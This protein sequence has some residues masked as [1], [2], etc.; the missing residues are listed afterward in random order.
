M[1][2]RAGRKVNKAGRSEGE[3]RFVQIPYWVLETAAARSL[4]GT[5]FKV[6]IYVVKRFNGVNNGA[7]GFG[8]RSGCFVR[9][10]GTGDLED[11]PIG[12]GKSALAAALVE[13]EAAGFLRCT[14]AS[15]FDQKRTTKEWRVTWLAAHG[16]PAT[17]DFATVPA[18][19]KKQKPVRQAGLCSELQSGQ[20]DNVV[21]K[22]PQKG[23]Y[24]P[25]GRTMS[26]FHSPPGRTHLVTIPRANG[27]TK[28]PAP[29]RRSG[30][31]RTHHC[32]T[33]TTINLF[34][35]RTGRSGFGAR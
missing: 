28:R 9:K 35:T 30:P 16:K 27:E 5:A 7:I 3:A 25:P 34:H 32:P 31:A 19:V 20:P 18:R 13:L 26:E 11:V 2:K 12:I 17:K 4:S 21:V 24:S 1:A 10:P 33:T 14:K 15:T 29:P 22:L 6:L 8:S 23:P